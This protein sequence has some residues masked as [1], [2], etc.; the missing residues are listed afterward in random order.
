M[1]ILLRLSKLNLVLHNTLFLYVT[2]SQIVDFHIIGF[3]S[4]P[5]P[6]VLYYDDWDDLKICIDATSF[7]NEARFVR[8]SCLPNAEVCSCWTF[9]LR[10]YLFRKTINKSGQL[11]MILLYTYMFKCCIFGVGGS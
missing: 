5:Q 6:F 1:V 11:L 7:G 4:R 3:V 8:R 2:C 9:F 10:S